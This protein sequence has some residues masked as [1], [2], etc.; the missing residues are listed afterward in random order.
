MF[1]ELIGQEVA[2]KKLEF[3][4][5]GYKNGG[6]LPFLLFT[7][8]QG[9][10][11]TAFARSVAK[12]MKNVDNNERH[13]I[14]VNC[15]VIKN[16]NDFFDKLIVPLMADY[17]YVTILF[18]EVHEL[19]KDIQ[20][21][22][23]TILNTEKGDSKDIQRPSGETIT[24]NFKK[25][26]LIFATTDQQKLVKPLLDRMTVIDFVPYD[27]DNLADII[28]VTC[29]EYEFC[30][31]ALNSISKTARFN[32]RNAVMRAREIKTLMAFS[33]SKKFTPQK[34]SFLRE[35]LN[36]QPYGLN[37][38]EIEVLRTI[39]QHSPCSLTKI[40]AN[41]GLS[42]QVIRQTIE[43]YLMKID[44]I[45]IDGKRHVTMHGKEVI[46]SLIE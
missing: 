3:Y 29:P 11:K 20:N 26:S 1:K 43:P 5:R 41:T 25:M 27:Y 35:Q 46:K 9:N 23:L 36:I 4:L 16:V 40:A 17:D 2:K 28:K 12:E 44:A 34:F 37:N 24:F 38:S 7:G 19:K 6:A 18:D 10:G 21:I 42:S 33:N 14:E 31:K 30:P 45:S 22:L 15:S 8:P 32:A 39:N 13:F